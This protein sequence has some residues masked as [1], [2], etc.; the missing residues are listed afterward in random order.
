MPASSPLTASWIWHAQPSYTPYHQA[1][2][3][4]KS[5]SLPA[6][7]GSAMLRIAVDGGYR[8]RINGAWVADGPARAWPEHFYYDEIDASPYLQAG[9]NQIE[10]IARHWQV[11][12]FHTRAQQAGLLV[13][14]DV[15]FPD[16]GASRILSDATWE[17]AHLPAW[18]AN[19]PKVSI[20][21]EPQELYDARLEESIRFTPAAVLYPADGGPWH[22]LLP[23]DVALLTRAPRH[24][25]RFLAANLLRRKRDLN[26]CLPVVRLAS[27]EPVVEANY[28]QTAAG[29]MATLL[30]LIAP[31]EIRL[32]LDGM[33]AAIAGQSREDGRYT[34][35]AGRHL[36]VACPWPV[37]NHRK[38]RELRIVDPPE[39]LRL[40]NPLPLSSSTPNPED[41]I[42]GDFTAHACR[43]ISETPYQLPSP[44][45]G[46]PL[47]HPKGRGAGMRVDS[48]E[49]ECRI[50]PKGLGR[51]VGAGVSDNPWLFLAL[52]QYAVSENDMDWVWFTSTSGARETAAA[53]CRA[54]FNRLLTCTDPAQLSAGSEFELRQLPAEEMFVH[55]THWLFHQREISGSAASLVDNPGALIHDNSAF[56]TVRPSPE[57]DL[58]L[59]YDL[60]EQSVGYFQF[61][62]IAPA[63]VCV[64]LYSV[65]YIAADGTV[66]HTGDNHNGL[67]YITRDGLNRFTSLKRR[68]GRYL[69][70]ALRDQHALVQIRLLRTIESTYPVEYRG[71]FSC[72]D[73]RLDRV[74]E[75]S[76]R[77]LALCME[78][79]FTDC[80]LYEQTYWV[81]DARNESIFAYDTFGAADI[82][83]RCL[84]L[85]AQSLERYPL[86]GGQV[87]SSWDMLLPAWS[88]LWG[89]AVWDYYFYTGDRTALEEFWPAVIANLR[90][91]QARLDS[92]GLFSGK[93][94]NMFDWTPVD[95]RHET[96][97]HNSLLLAG[98]LDA[99]Q[100]AAAVL[101][102]GANKTWLADFRARLSAAINACWDPAKNAYPDAILEDGTA[103]SSTCMHT[104]FLSLLYDVIPPEHAAAALA[105][106]LTPPQGM[107]PV[108]SPFAM[109]Y[110]YEALAKTGQPAAILAS[111]YANYLP[112]LA[113]G[114][115]TV[116]EVF[117]TSGDR[118]GG[119]PTRSHCHAWSSAP[120][121]F[122]PQ[123][124]LGIRQ[125]EPG[126]AAYT[127]SPWVGDLAW[128]RGT[129][130]TARGPLEVS[131]QRDGQQLSL[132][133]HAPEGVAVKL[134]SNPSLAGLEIH[135]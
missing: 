3:A 94:W 112:M 48:D 52:P 64:D 32:E 130:C 135:S 72:S 100:K 91:A 15:L 95:D 1:I 57:G 29:A 19:V 20:Q 81:G 93:F 31:A 127:I 43:E 41:K 33:Q 47:V 14:L 115:T 118:P 24:F 123:V 36:L 77:T 78:D 16:G 82:A 107:V 58:E 128:A 104:S 70:L 108:G 61:E 25:K 26:F 124:V 69:F 46:A 87:P 96:V 79:T 8:L 111:I 22:D 85:A 106:A 113:D 23:R 125:D 56:T 4:R 5:F 80:P 37:F 6:R 121:H 71:A 62:L 116:W 27:K 50:A 45:Q 92:H 103:S 21:M 39:G 60:G 129:V 65:E 131:W 11:G 126:G 28:Y 110:Y 40:V 134:A 54:A 89:I 74:W 90:G 30:E 67:R 59:V 117:P 10:V 35:P 86:A 13:Q 102:D 132:T 17:T 83:R 49:S 9:D 84:R 51:P 66:Q 68:A 75:I 119:F 101:A 97:L 42:T 18:A 99:A 2:L 34:L 12:D 55:S 109:M 53:G 7:P 133:I 114:A 73:A 63:G 98:A 44:S 105:N 122:L 76:A 120:L 38:E 88:F